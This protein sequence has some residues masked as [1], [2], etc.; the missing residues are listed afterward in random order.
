MHATDDRHG[1]RADED[2]RLEQV[3]E[4][5][6]EVVERA[7]EVRRHEA[8]DE[9]GVLAFE[10]FEDLARGLADR[11]R[12]DRMLRER[13]RVLRHRGMV[14]GVLGSVETARRA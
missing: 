11:V 3:A 9:V 7:D 14:R 2:A 5:E 8:H 4:R 13:G 6:R 10:R 1:G 12:G